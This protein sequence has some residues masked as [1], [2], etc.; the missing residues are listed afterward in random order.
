MW[1]QPYDRPPRGSQRIGLP[2]VAVECFCGGVVLTPVVFDH[3]RHVRDYD[4]RGNWT[5]S[6]DRNLRMV[7]HHGYAGGN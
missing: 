3:D 2:P 4:V 1:A 7:K 5:P 6:W